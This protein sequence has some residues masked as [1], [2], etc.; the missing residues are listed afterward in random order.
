MEQTIEDRVIDVI[1]HV[2][3]YYHDGNVVLDTNPMLD[4]DFDSLDLVET[5]MA[6]ER[7]FDI[8]IPDDE[9]WKEWNSVREIVDYVKMKLETED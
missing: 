8:V 2:M 5:T 9:V 4:L 6:L 1:K 3:R 7:E